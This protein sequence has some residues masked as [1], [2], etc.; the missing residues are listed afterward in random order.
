MAANQ[1]DRKG[2]DTGGGPVA[3]VYAKALIGALEGSGQTDPVMQELESLIEDCLDALPQFEA[4]LAS[5]RV[6]HDDRQLSLSLGSSAER[7]HA[8]DH[9]EAVLAELRALDPARTTPIDALLTLQRWRERL[10]E[11]A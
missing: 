2:I 1:S 6:P 5:P 9:E 10:E 8:N 7:S 4:V 11:E 3:S